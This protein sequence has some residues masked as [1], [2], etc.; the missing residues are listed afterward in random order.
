[1]FRFEH[2]L[3]KQRKNTSMV[4]RKPKQAGVYDTGLGVSW[5]D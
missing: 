2:K 1:M 5:N 3:E 4:E